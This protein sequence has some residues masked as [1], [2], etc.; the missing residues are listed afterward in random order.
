[1]ETPVLYFYS[2]RELTADVS[3][4]FPQGIIT[5]WYPDKSAADPS[6]IMPGMLD[7]SKVPALHWKNVRVLPR[8][9]KGDVLLKDESGSHYYAARETDAS[10][11][12]TTTDKKTETEKFLFYRGVGNFSA[13]LIVKP[14][15]NAGRLTLRNAGAEELADLFVYQVDANGRLSW[16]PVAKLASGESRDVEVLQATGSGAES[17]SAALRSALV[18]AGLYEKEAAA[19]V[20]TWEGSWF[21]E[22]G[23]RVL[24]TLPRAWADRTLPLTVAPTPKAIERVMVGRAEIITPQMEAA[25]RGQVDRYIAAKPEERAKIVAETRALGFG[26][27]SEAVLSRVRNG[28]HTQE[29]FQR[30]WELVEATRSVPQPAAKL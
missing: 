2:D 26:R 18:R 23:V 29:Y 22:R 8:A 16:T 21:S 27:F 7:A 30:S 9:A 28:D 14:V 10:L 13:P 19:M 17:L 3:V 20:K 1:M 11:L 5:E 12:R 25:L 24:Y 4:H 6:Q 15:G